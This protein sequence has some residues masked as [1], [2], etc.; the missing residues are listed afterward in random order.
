M[1][2]IFPRR[3]PAPPALWAVFAEQWLGLSRTR[4]ERFWQALQ[5]SQWSRCREV[6]Q[7]VHLHTG[8]DQTTE[9]RWALLTTAMAP[10]AV[11]AVL[12][13]TVQEGT[14]PLVVARQLEEA[15]LQRTGR[16][17]GWL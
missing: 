11:I 16:E 17:G 5:R 12:E 4:S 8:L 9:A 14:M 15:V 3:P 6:R 13:A 2:S 10:S 7:L 1:A